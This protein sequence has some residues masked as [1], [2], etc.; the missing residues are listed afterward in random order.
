MVTIL[1]VSIACVLHFAFRS[2]GS[3]R[4]L[5]LDEIVAIVVFNVDKSDIKRNARV[6]HHHALDFLWI[7]IN[8][9]I[10]GLDEIG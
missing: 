9:L 6:L 8:R 1:S 4:S 10:F 7:V 2:A 5:N 3:V